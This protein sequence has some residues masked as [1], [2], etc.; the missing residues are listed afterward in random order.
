L[1]PLIVN[2]LSF[3]AVF[4]TVFA[5]NALLIDLHSSE[6]KRVKSRMEEQFR[7][8]QRDRIRTSPLM[9]DFSTIAAEATSENSKK[10]SI[11]SSFQGMVEQSGLEITATKLLQY[12]VASGVLSALFTGI[13]F[14]SP[15]ATFLFLIVGALVP[16]FYVQ[17]KR[18]KRLEKLRAQL[19]D[20][21]DMMARVI[22]AGQTIT[23][24]IQAVADEFSEPISLEFLYCYEQMNLGLPAEAALRDLGRRTGLL[25][26]KIFILAVVVHR[27]TGGN[28]AQLLDKLAHVVRERFR[29]RGMIKSLTAQGRFQAAILLSLP[30]F[31]FL[32]LFMVQPEYEKTLLQYPMMIVTALSMMA[33]GALWI[34]KIVNFDY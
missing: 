23:Q 4:L 12:M 3:L 8:K 13:I 27:Q 29:I 31:M 9:K 2:T 1:T 20:A 15:M 7:K 10:R 22:R 11:R 25:E 24:A 26:I 19:S 14:R 32:L 17:W 30:P 33:V 6:R 28:L 5:T 34:R 16:M 18:H 21:F